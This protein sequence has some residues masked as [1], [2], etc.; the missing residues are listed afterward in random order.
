MVSCLALVPP[1]AAAAAGAQAKIIKV[2]PQFLDAQGRHALAPSLYERDAYQFYLRKRPG[3]RL[4]LRLAVQWKAHGVDWKKTVLRAELR[5]ATDNNLHTIT[6]E[7]P[8]KKCG[9]FGRWSEFTIEGQRYQTFG[10][11]IAWRVT[12]LE[13]GRQIAQQQSFLWS[14]FTPSPQP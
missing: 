8:V 2:L 4:G 3:L 14:P 11:L 1:A 10:Q 7:Q 5:G 13:A 9:W 6:L 12:L